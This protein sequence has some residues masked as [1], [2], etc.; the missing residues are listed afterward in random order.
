[1][2]TTNPTWPELGLNMNPWSKKPATNHLSY[3]TDSRKK[4][5]CFL[6]QTSEGGNERNSELCQELHIIINIR[7]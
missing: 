4:M 5:Q 7:Q 3:D 2:P 6:R 1:L